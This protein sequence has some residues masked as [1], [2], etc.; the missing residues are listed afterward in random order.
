MK[1][2][3][4]TLKLINSNPTG[5]GISKE[6]LHSIIGQRSAT[7]VLG[8]LAESHNEDTPFPTILLTGSHGLGKSF[9][10]GKVAEA[11]GR[12]FVEVNCSELE[13]NKDLVE[14]IFINSV[15][16]D[17]PVTLLFDEAHK[18]SSDPRALLLSYLNPSKTNCN[19]VKYKQ[20]IIEYDMTLINVVFATTDA[21]KMIK[22]LRNR[23]Q[24]IYLGHYKN[25]DLLEI[26]KMYCPDIV[27]ECDKSDIAYACRGRARDTFRLAEHIQRFCN[28]SNTTVLTQEGWEILKDVFGIFP[29][30]LNAQ[31]VHLLQIIQE[32]GVISCRN[33]AIRMGI[34]EEN[35]S[36][37]ME[38]RPK[39]LGLID[40]GT[41]GRFLTDSGDK[42][43]K[44]I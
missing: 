13:T 28:T 14:G 36:S 40:N 11:L 26:L 24:E 30:G 18:I 16:G 10:A 9:L 44:S 42:Y 32:S 5:L 27:I 2:D 15:M 23:C 17:V 19:H 20:T 41:R 43:A 8:F 31:E 3:I 25:R 39:E 29:L 22:P 6:V 4:H 21:Y 1:N 35:V 33:I 38:I 34:S 37:E 7:K 12:K